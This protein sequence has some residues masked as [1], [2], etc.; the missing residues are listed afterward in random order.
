M[1]MER[2]EGQHTDLT[3][4]VIMGNEL[5]LSENRNPFEGVP[6]TAEI[7]LPS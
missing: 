5:N 2:L 7:Q 3:P 6:L 1:A 4:K